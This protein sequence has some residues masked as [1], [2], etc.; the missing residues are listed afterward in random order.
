MKCHRKERTNI[1]HFTSAVQPASILNQVSFHIKWI[2][3]VW[4]F[5]PRKQQRNALLSVEVFPANIVSRQIDRRSSQL[6]FTRFFSFFPVKLR[7]FAFDSIERMCEF[8]FDVVQSFPPVKHRRVMNWRLSW[9]C[10]TGKVLWLLASWDWKY[11]W[12]PC[13]AFSSLLL[14]KGILSA[15][16]GHF[17]IGKWGDNHPETHDSVMSIR[18]HTLSRVYPS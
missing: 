9:G 12:C 1:F 6:Y 4:P 14:L 18:F 8:V 17:F 11:F 3:N 2:R 5:V 10:W 15:T 16:P 7:P 13:W